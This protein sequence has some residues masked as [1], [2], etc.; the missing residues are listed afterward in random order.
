MAQPHMTSSDPLLFIDTLLFSWDKN[1]DYATKLVADVPQDRMVYQPEVGMNHPAWVLSHLNAYHPVIVSLVRGETFDDPKE[2]PFGMKSKPVAD[3][4][5][6]P[7]KAQLVESF[8]QGHHDVTAA[9]RT[10]GPGVLQG[11]VP[12]ERWIRY[13]PS[14]GVVLGY[15]MLVHESTH[16]GQLSA[17]RRVQGMPS[18]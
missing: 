10:A 14:V 8:I 7:P 11:E 16:F 17:W 18:V 12:L 15:L 9:L 3:V 6:Y 2:H 5:V 1:L 13:F 4:A